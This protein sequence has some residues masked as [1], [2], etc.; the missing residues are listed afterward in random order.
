MALLGAY[1]P[2]RSWDCSC[3]RSRSGFSA[4]AGR[5]GSSLRQFQTRID[6]A[7]QPA[8]IA[9]AL[10]SYLAKR[11]GL[12]WFNVR[13]DNNRRC[14]PRRRVSSAGRSLRANSRRV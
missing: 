2:S 13:P 5:F 1:H 11:L 7:E 10:R 6:R 3:V 12:S 8:E 14:T 9:T 4:L